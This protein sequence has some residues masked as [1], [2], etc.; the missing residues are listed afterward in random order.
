MTKL[1]SLEEMLKAGMH[2]GHQTS[3]WHP[4]MAPFIFGSRAGVHIIDLQKTRKNLTEA[5]TFITKIVAEKKSILLVGTKDQVKNRLSEIASALELPYVKN[6]WIGGT[7]TNF[8]IIKRL[9]KHYVD[10]QEQQTAGKLAKYTKKEQVG[11]DKELK[12]LDM[13]IGG[14]TNLKKMP[15][16]IF[17]WDIKHEK[18]A[19]TEARKKG[20]PVVAVCDTNVNPEG[21]KYIIPANDDAIKTIKMILAL[22]GDAVKEGQKQAMERSA[23]E[24]NKVK[25]LV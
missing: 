17:I 10:L 22:V 13:R 11:F 21:V 9:V 18:T 16:A 5:L 19:L 15:D 8:V 24:I 4:K 6:R 25:P 3:K 14:L 2:F 23:E 7:L 1:P 20:V 12:K